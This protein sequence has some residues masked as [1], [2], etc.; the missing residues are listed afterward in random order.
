MDEKKIEIIKLDDLK[1]YLPKIKVTCENKSFYDEIGKN[2][3]ESFAIS[4]DGTVIGLAYIEDDDEEGF[5]YVYI[6]DEYRNKGYGYKAAKAA[7]GMLKS[8]PGKIVT[9]IRNGDDTA[10]KF[11]EK[12]GYRAWFSSAAM[13]YS[14]GKFED[15]D[16]PVRQYTDADFI[17][18]F[19][20]AEEAFHKMRVETG[21]FPD[22]K[23]DE[24]DEE[25]RKFMAESAE[26]RYVYEVGGEI[27]G[28]GKLDGDELDVVCIKIAQQGKGYGR[29][30][31]KHLVNVMI[32]K[33]IKEP[34]LWCVVGNNKARKL[35]ESL[36][37][38]EVGRA[39][40][41]LKTV[42]KQQ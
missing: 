30:L 31:V 23:V 15:G 24:P 33:G 17:D 13:K 22:S 1:E 7:E 27:V 34:L 4:L 41:S 12:L 14:G 42:E 9:G 6:F 32:D 35:Y 10:K 36:G 29:K 40:Y 8:S 25:S 5:I 21:L 3:E 11:C 26:R 39:D 28:Y 19:V 2:T 20:L 16:I 37:F 18:S 38:V